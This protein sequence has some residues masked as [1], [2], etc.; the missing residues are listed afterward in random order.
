MA[1]PEAEELIPE[2]TDLRAA[3]QDMDSGRFAEML[4]D[5]KLEIYNAHQAA[6]EAEAQRVLDEGIKR[7]D[8]Q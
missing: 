2:L 1:K 7:G 4:S 8:F 6:I 3:N 5:E